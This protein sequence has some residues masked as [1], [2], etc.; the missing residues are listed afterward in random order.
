MKNIFTFLFVM[1]LSSFAV[2]QK[3]TVKIIDGKPEGKSLFTEKMYIFPKFEEGKIK[4]QDGTVY[5]GRV[6]INTINQTVEQITDKGDTSGI[7]VEN[8]VKMVT[9]GRNVFFKIGKLYYQIIETNGDISMGLHRRIKLEEEKVEGAYG[10]ASEVASVSKMST[11]S[12][13]GRTKAIGSEFNLDYT[14]IEDYFLIYKGKA[15]APNKKNFI[16]AFPKAAKKIETWIDENKT[17]LS[18]NESQVALF[19]L[20]ISY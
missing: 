13:F 4:I 3:G 16:K 17:D 1:L 2:A 19:R 11:V 9:V 5:E 7:S 14:Y 8:M 15:V 10:Y 12:D 20:A 6:N 18:T